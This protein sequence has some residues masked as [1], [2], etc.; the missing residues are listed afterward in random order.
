[1][2]PELGKRLAHDE[3]V[4]LIRRWIAEMDDPPAADPAP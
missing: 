4:E 3:A 2:M 1:M